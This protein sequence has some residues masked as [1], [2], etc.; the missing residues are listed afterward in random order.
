MMFRDWLL[1][2][3]K[4]SEAHS[5]SCVLAYINSV[6]KEIE[7]WSK[8]NIKEKDLYVDEGGREENS[9][10]TVLYG[11]HTND[12]QDVK[13]IIDK[14]YS[15]EIKLGKISKFESKDYDVLKV[16]IESPYLHLINKKLKTLPFTTKFPN[17]VPHM[18]I[19][20][21]KKDSCNHL[22]GN[23]DLVQKI[24]VSELTFSSKDKIKT[25]FEL[26]DNLI[27]QFHRIG[28]NGN[29]YW[30]KMG[31]GI[32]FTDGQ[33]ILLL[34]RANIGD[35]LGYWAPPGGKAKEGEVPL[36]TAKRES[37]EECGHNEGQRFSDHHSQDG[38]HHFYTYLMT[39]KP[40][41]A[42]LSKEHD[43]SKWVD[44]DE[45]ENMKLHPKFKDSWP[46]YKRAIERKFN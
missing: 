26:K 16:E 6:K 39:V 24:K 17:Y 38:G 43:M 30:G 3:G 46:T 11:L 31:A 10:V 29:R 44:L 36:E 8:K 34:R 2:E 40:F 7:N 22:L 19:A 13:P 21:V 27:E 25:K 35:Y 4:D 15:F 9:H 33:K 42:K 41:E 12:F 32:I 14:L 45:V 23:K 1:I 5:Y 18:T 28:K 20:Y 37:K